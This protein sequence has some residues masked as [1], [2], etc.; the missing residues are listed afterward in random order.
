MFTP[1]IMSE[2]VFSDGS[3]ATVRTDTTLSS[4]T[5]VRTTTGGG[6]VT[7]LATMTQFLRSDAHAHAD[8]S[9]SSITLNRGVSAFNW[10][11][12]TYYGNAN[13]LYIIRSGATYTPYT[14]FANV[15]NLSGVASGTIAYG[16][17]DVALFVYIH[18]VGLVGA[19]PDIVFVPRLP[20]HQIS[21]GVNQSYWPAN[22]Y[23][24]GEIK[25]V[26][27]DRNYDVG[28]YSQILEL[29]NGITALGGAAT[30]TS[31]EP[32]Y[33]SAG[34]IAI[35][36]PTS[37]I[38]PSANIDVRHFNSDTGF[39][40][41]ENL[42]LAG[43]PPSY[44][45]AIYFVRVFAGA[46]TH[47]FIDVTDGVTNAAAASWSSIVA[48]TTFLS[49]GEDATITSLVTTP[50]IAGQPATFNLAINDSGNSGNIRYSLTIEFEDGSELELNS[51]VLLAGGSVNVSFTFIVPW[52]TKIADITIQGFAA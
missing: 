50:I 34:T 31:I 18:T 49:D 42:G 2:L 37:F 8:A 28:T 45:L 11:G 15:P 51:P 44:T 39:I 32:L 35:G 7:N 21:F 52:A 25:S 27:L 46:V 22:I 36:S 38:A 3:V 26:Y 33:R 13:T 19:S 17:G 24:N 16:A 41:G 1:A 10:G 23:V 14:G 20:T 40:S 5:L 12:T 30:D 43:I 48:G 29:A 9:A 47:V 4:L 6:G